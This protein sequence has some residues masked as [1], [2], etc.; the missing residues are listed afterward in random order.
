MTSESGQTG[1]MVDHSVVAAV[2]T[3]NDHGHHLPLR[4]RQS[5][6]GVHNVTI[7]LQV[8]RQRLRVEAVHPEDVVHLPA[9]W[10]A[11]FGV[12]LGELAF[13]LFVR[14]DLDPCSLLNG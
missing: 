6:G 9:G 4:T 11:V 13:G 12:E 7:D 10:I 2:D 14:H 8:I 1:R 3:G 5:A